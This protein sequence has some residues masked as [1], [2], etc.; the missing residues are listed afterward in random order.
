MEI[1]EDV[2]FYLMA[3]VIFVTLTLLF[4]LFRPLNKKNK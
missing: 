1:F 2:N 4:L 3:G